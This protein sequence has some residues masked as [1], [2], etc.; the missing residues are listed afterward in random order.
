MRMFCCLI[1]IAVLA[2]VAA[3]QN[4][5]PSSSPAATHISG[6]DLS[7]L[8]KNANP[9]EDFYQYACGGWL[10]NNPIPAD[11]AAWGRFSELAERNRMFMRDILEQAAKATDRTPNEQKIGDYYASC[12]D[13]TAIN[14]KGVAPL[15]P[16]LDQINSLQDKSQ[17]TSLIANLHRYGVDVLF[18]FGSGA[19]FK[20]AK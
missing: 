4:P 10:K 1:A 18:S 2:G 3:A 9:C 20:N 14:K 8:D 16:A 13:E 19:D 5:T 6:L 12:M 15:Q 17:L 7:A 11:Q